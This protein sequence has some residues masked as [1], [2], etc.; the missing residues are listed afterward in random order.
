MIYLFVSTDQTYTH[1][2]THIHIQTHTNGNGK[3]MHYLLGK[4]LRG[5]AISGKDNYCR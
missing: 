4:S 3:D 5:C 2:Y 1:T